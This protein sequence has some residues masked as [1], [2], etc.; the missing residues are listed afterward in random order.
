LT[1][2]DLQKSSRVNCT[3]PDHFAV[4]PNDT[5]VQ[6]NDNPCTAASGASW[7]WLYEP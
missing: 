4:A 5:P 1:I 3:V 7:Y 6:I 2:S